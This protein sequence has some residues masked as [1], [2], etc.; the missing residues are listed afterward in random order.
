MRPTAEFHTFGERFIQDIHLIAENM[1]QLMEFTLSPFEGDARRRLK[2]FI[3]DILRDGVSDEELQG[4]WHATPADI[5]FHDTH[6]LRMVL[7]E[8]YGRL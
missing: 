3:G 1:D 5:Y 7:S 8:A 6:E 2:S 4:L